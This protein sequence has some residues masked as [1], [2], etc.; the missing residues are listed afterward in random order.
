MQKY[1]GGLEMAAGE[2]MK[3]LGGRGV[4]GNDRNA[5]YIYIPGI[6]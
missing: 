6:P 2:K 1:Y 3:I 4:H 5:Q